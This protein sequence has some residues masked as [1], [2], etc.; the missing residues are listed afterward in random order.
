M[1]TTAQIAQTVSIRISQSDI[2]TL[3]TTPIIIVPA[4]VGFINIFESATVTYFYKNTVFTNVSNLFGFGLVPTQPDIVND[5][6]PVPFSVSNLING[7]AMLGT[8][9]ITSNSFTPINPYPGQMSKPSMSNAAIVFGT[10]INPT[11]GDTNST[12]SIIATYTVLAQ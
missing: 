6:I 4:A 8:P 1:A 7:E 9:Q 3:G 5:P 10:N 11:G 2:L 12:L